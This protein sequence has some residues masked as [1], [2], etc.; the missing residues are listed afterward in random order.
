VRC[1]VRAIA[2]VAQRFNKPPDQLGAE[3]TC[4]YQLFL[5][6]EKRVKRSSYIQ[7]I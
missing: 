6:N 3:E 5:L 7:A 1:Y 2:E 4:A